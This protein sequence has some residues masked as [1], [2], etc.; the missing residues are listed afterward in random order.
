MHMKYFSEM[1]PDDLMARIVK[2][3]SDEILKGLVYPLM[4]RYSSVTCDRE[5]L[6]RN[7]YVCVNIKASGK[8]IVAVDIYP[9]CAESSDVN[10]SGNDRCLGVVFSLFRRNGHKSL[11]KMTRGS[12]NKTTDLDKTIEN[13]HIGFVRRMD[14]FRRMEKK[15]CLNEANEKSA[16][17]V[18][19]LH[20]IINVV[21]SNEQGCL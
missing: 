21:R 10:N 11:Y 5:Y 9:D 6:K 20:A 17:I 2:G 19:E 7:D 4:A 18:E 3:L 12:K 13:K 15:I 8:E 16:Q 14:G 1:E